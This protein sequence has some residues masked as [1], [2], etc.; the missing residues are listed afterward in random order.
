MPG[1]LQ[2]NAIISL[3]ESNSISKE[4]YLLYLFNESSFNI[5]AASV[6]SMYNI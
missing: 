3:N 5:I 4:P 6:L 2:E 1:F